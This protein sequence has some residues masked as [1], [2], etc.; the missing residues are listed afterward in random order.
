[1][2]RLRARID[3]PTLKAGK[4]DRNRERMY[5]PLSAQQHVEQSKHAQCEEPTTSSTR[6]Q[7]PFIKLRNEA[8]ACYM[9][10]ADDALDG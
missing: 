8:N 5:K 7:Y 9:N 4:T 3:L 6:V 1:M 2:N 10:V